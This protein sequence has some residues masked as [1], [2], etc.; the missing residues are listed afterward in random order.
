MVGPEKKKKFGQSLTRVLAVNSTLSR[1]I[2]TSVSLFQE[3]HRS[4]MTIRA[5]MAKITGMNGHRT[6]RFPIRAARM[7]THAISVL[8][9]FALDSNHMVQYSG[10]S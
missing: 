8:D 3:L 7:V 2:E 4:Q 9:T 10:C 5:K 1:M 6:G